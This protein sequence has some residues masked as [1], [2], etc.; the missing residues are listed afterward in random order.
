MCQVTKYQVVVIHVFC[1][2]MV[3]FPISLNSTLNNDWD[4]LYSRFQVI[5]SE[6]LRCV[7]NSCS[8]YQNIMLFLRVQ[9]V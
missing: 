3:I 2:Q 4:I 9:S 8:S 6:W 1:N 5:Y 7:Q